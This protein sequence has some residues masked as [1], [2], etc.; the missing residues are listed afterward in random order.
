MIP[1]LQMFLKILHPGPGSGGI[2]LART[3]MAPD[4]GEVFVRK[5][6]AGGGDGG[7][8]VGR[9][10]GGGIGGGVDGRVAHGGFELVTRVG[11]FKV[12]ESGGEPGWRL[13]LAGVS[14]GLGEGWVGEGHSGI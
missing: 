4:P 5:V 12:G 7:L 8:G 6:F 3:I 2:Q 10:H 9:N 11:A 1:I 14:L 13:G